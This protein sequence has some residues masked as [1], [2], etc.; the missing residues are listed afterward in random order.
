MKTAASLSMYMH[1][2]YLEKKQLVLLQLR[3][4]RR[5][6]YTLCKCCNSWQRD[7]PWLLL[8]IGDMNLCLPI[9]ARYKLYVNYSVVFTLVPDDVQ[10]KNAL[11]LIEETLTF[12]RR[13]YLL[14][15]LPEPDSCVDCTVNAVDM[16]RFVT[17][18]KPVKST[19]WVVNWDS[20]NTQ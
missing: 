16:H 9:I 15:A 1:R 12:R 3:T 8:L 2:C 18:A 14:G 7:K 5:L 4:V 6:L 11:P 20:H 13:T 10:C 19:K 17:P